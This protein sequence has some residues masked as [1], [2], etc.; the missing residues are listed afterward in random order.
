VT[1]FDYV[2][3]ARNTPLGSVR[4]AGPTPHTQ[5]FPIGLGSLRAILLHVAGPE[6]GYV[7]VLVTGEGDAQELRH[8]NPFTAEQLPDVES[9]AAAWDR[10]R[11][12]TRGAL[13]DLGDPHRP[14]A[15]P[16]RLQLTKG[17][18][19][20][21]ILFHEIHHRARAMAMLRR[22]GIAAQNL[23]YGMLVAERIPIG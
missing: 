21:S 10:R 7:Q 19:A 3:R 9:L 15:P 4:A 17:G 1:Y 2:V 16:V 12:V 14:T 6:W 18:L 22:C 20:G 5:T 11:P 23:G 13:V 8:A